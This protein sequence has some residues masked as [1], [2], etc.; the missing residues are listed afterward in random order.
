MKYRVASLQFQ[1]KNLQ[2]SA[3]LIHWLIASYGTLLWSISIRAACLCGDH[4]ME[5]W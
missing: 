5:K 2:L 4:V 1:V 3:Y